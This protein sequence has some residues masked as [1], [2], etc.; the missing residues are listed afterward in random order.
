MKAIV[1]VGLGFGDEGKGAA[2]DF[3]VRTLGANLV[4]RYSGGAQAGHNVELPDG[5]RHTFSQFGAGT[6]AGANTFIGP[7]M[8]LCPTTMVPEAEHLSSLGIDDPWSTIV[9]HPECLVATAYHQV[10]NRLRELSRGDARH[11]SCGLGIGESR[12]YWLRYGRDAVF[13]RDLDD[14]AT[15][16]PKLALMR[17]RFLLEMQELSR[18]DAELSGRLHRLLPLDEANL[19]RHAADRL[20][21]ASRM[22]QSDTV[23]FEGA[24]GVLLDQWKGFHP[25]TTWSTVTPQPALEMLAEFPNVETT[26]IGITRAYATR[27]GAGPFPTACVEM[28]REMT[29]RG[30]PANDWQ[31]GMRFGPLD[32]ILT[33]Y[34]ARVSQVDGIF[35][36]GLDQLSRRPRMATCYA[37]CGRLEEPANLRQQAE[38]TSLLESASTIQTETTGDG[39][40]EEL[41]RIAPIIGTARGATY[42]HRELLSQPWETAFVAAAKRRRVGESIAAT[43]R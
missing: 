14:P 2:V 13:A 12:Q 6:L 37:D 34:A 1:T 29:D 9:V 8:I 32:L 36:S 35:V 27:H 7:R 38:L 18:L 43:E 40:L 31:G 16:I 15:L 22:P 17:E 21:I 23:V 3:L 10:M 41:A 5:R 42:R 19:L 4:V 30:N 39:I 20:A 33:E 11:G 28:S 24:Q 25:Y 26:V